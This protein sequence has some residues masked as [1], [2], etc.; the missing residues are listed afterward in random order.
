[1]CLSDDEAAYRGSNFQ[2]A[3]PDASDWQFL[4]PEVVPKL[5]SLHE[6]NVKIVL[7]T[8]QAGK[9]LKLPRRAAVSS[10]Q[11]GRARRGEREDFTR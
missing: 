7:F 10:A 9:R 2:L 4:Y 3:K 5:K 8:N 1:M 6:Q 11:P